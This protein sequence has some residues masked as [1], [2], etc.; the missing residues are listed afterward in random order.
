[1]CDAVEANNG[2]VLKFIGDAMLAIFPVA[3]DPASACLR[4]LSAARAAQDALAEENQR[5]RCTSG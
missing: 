1:M 4:A 2:E 3:D 5:F